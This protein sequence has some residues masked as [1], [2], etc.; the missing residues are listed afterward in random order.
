MNYDSWIQSGDPYDYDEVGAC[1]NVNCP[2]YGVDMEYRV[3]VEY[4]AGERP[5]CS[6]CYEY[7]Y[8]E[9]E[10]EYKELRAELKRTQE[11]EKDR[12]EQGY[13]TEPSLDE[14]ERQ[15]YLGIYD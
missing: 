6:T 4:G 5:E 10:V 11:L 14:Y 15:A 8:G 9:D 2:D 3:H 12:P 1:I 7:L 13:Y